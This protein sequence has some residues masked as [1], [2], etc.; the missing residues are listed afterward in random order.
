M[1]QQNPNAVSETAQPSVSSPAQSR[2]E[3]IIMRTFDAPPERVFSWWIN[4]GLLM[5]WWAPKGWSTPS[6][7]VDLRPGGIFHYCMRS[8]EGKDFWGRGVYREIAAPQRL[9]YSDSFSNGEGKMVE[10]ARYGMSY[11]YPSETQVTVTFA[12]QEGKTRVTV[13]HDVP[14][15]IPERSGMQQGWTEMLER[16]GSEL[17]IATMHTEV[18]EKEVIFS[19][20]I[21]APRARVFKAW[22]DAMQ[23]G[24]W[25]GPNGFTSVCEMDARPGGTYRVVMRSPEGVEYPLKGTLLEVVES[26]RLAMT[27]DAEEHP[28]E[29]HE[30]L[31]QYR[32][33]GEAKHGLKINLAVTFEECDGKTMLAI[34][35]RFESN[36]DRDAA[37]K[38]GMAEGWAQ[39]LERLDALLR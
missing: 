24:Q 14:E 30:M 10:P 17:A 19:R 4:P 26:E 29:W 1:D 32:L 34:R 3:V 8:P 11:G 36:S 7:K 27:M 38:M 6:C 18:G 5:R 33:P 22:T 15:S 31:N 37:L 2:H 25:W 16:L 21:A 35:S 39:S 13:L 9:V 20:V 12:G 23:L 28:D